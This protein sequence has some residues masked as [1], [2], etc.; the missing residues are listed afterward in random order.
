M[1]IYVVNHKNTSLTLPNNYINFGVGDS[2]LLI[3][4]GS[5]DNISQKNSNYCELTAMYWIWKNSSELIVGLNHYRRIFMY[6]EICN[7]GIVQFSD[8]E[9]LLNNYD[10]IVPTI[11]HENQTV[12]DHYVNSHKKTDMDLT[13][14]IIKGMYPNYIDDFEYVMNQ[15]N[16]Y[17]FNILA[18]HKILFDEY[19]DWL[20]TIL[21]NLEKIN[22]IDG[23]DDY[24]KRVYGF[25]SER[26]FNVWLLHHKY[27]QK[28]LPL[29]NIKWTKEKTFKKKQKK[30]SSPNYF[31][32]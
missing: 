14:E 7:D 17:G 32:Y 25:L 9:E 11:H 4:D 12:Y 21:F 24:Q 5:G 23:Y 27:K 28:E 31:L 20:F 6:E 1:S 22:N 29:K 15:N 19:C 3:N 8:I 18:T 16:E 10:I 26:L 13:F 2:K 30:L